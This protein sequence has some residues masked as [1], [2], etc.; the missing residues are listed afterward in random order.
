MGIAGQFINRA[1]GSELTI[2]KG[3]E[4]CTSEVQVSSVFALDG[5][6]VT[7]VDSPGFDDTN[8]S[9]A[10]ILREVTG[11]LAKTYVESSCY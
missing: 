2:G 8:K 7:L 1:S 3:L 9:E 5:Q 6:A 4:S 11:F 10:E